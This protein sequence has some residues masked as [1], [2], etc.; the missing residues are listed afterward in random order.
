MLCFWPLHRETCWGSSICSTPQKPVCTSWP[1]CWT[2][3]GSTR[4]VYCIPFGITAA[5][6]GQR[7]SEWPRRI[8][9]SNW[10][11]DWEESRAEQNRKNL[12]FNKLQSSKLRLL[13]GD[14]TL[15]KQTVLCV[16][17]LVCV[18]LCLTSLGLPGCHGGG[19]LW[20]GGGC[21]LPLPLLRSGSLCLHCDVMCHPQGV[22]TNCLQVSSFS[23]CLSALISSSVSVQL[24]ALHDSTSVCMC[25]NIFYNCTMAQI[26]F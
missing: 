26:V 14:P 10:K 8:A 3:G 19:V 12:K 2:A 25:V 18:I 23:A 22:E 4:F 24:H 5:Q 7:K 17:R 21:A 11:W 20:W 16:S 9:A 1:P 6:L 15:W 13:P